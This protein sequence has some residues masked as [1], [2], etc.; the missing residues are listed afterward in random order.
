MIHYIKLEKSLMSICKVSRIVYQ[1]DLCELVN[2][3]PRPP[4]Q[5]YDLVLNDL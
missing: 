2:K 4:S 3:G 5:Q 1:S